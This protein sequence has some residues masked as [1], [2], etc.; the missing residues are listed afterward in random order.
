MQILIP[1]P[2]FIESS[3]T[4]NNEHLQQQLHNIS[5]AMNAIHEVSHLPL[6]NNPFVKSWT[7]HEPQ[8]CEYGITLGEECIARRLRSAAVKDDY[9]NLEWHLGNATS[10]DFSLEKP[11]WFGNVEIHD[12]HKAFLLR[13]DLAHYKVHFD[14]TLSDLPIRHPR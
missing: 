11:E 3:G 4:F 6:R 12:S 1:I 8:L 10:G 2:D 14:P 7:G 5:L 13:M 9:E